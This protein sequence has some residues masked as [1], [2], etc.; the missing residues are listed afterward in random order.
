[1]N[2]RPARGSPSARCAGRCQCPRPAPAAPTKAAAT[3]WRLSPT[4]RAA[5]G[6]RPPERV[7]EHEAAE[8]CPDQH[9]PPEQRH[10]AE[11]AAGGPFDHAPPLPSTGRAATRPSAARR[12]ARPA[13]PH[14][15]AAATRGHTRRSFQTST[16]R[17]S[18]PPPAAC[19]ANTHAL[20]GEP[21]EP[22]RKSGSH[23]QRDETRQAP[24]GAARRHCLS[25]S[26]YA[27]LAPTPP[28]ECGKPPIA[29][30]SPRV[31][32]QPT[33]AGAP[34]SSRIRPTAGC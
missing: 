3:N 18:A 6:P 12:L 8:E 11:P 26:T 27:P 2:R 31:L 25:D 28:Q 21:A 34:P 17:A 20:C 9:V 19:A 24:V 13:A 4:Q 16:R 10:P 32:I 1:M 14:P 33:N 7:D 29:L 5:Q 15:P 23:A 22:R 30:T